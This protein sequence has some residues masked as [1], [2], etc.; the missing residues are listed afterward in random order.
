MR[1]A[2]FLR[3]HRRYIVNT[4]AAWTGQRKYDIDKLIRKMAGRCDDM[5]LYLQK[6]DMEMLSE[7]TAFVTAVMCNVHLF[8]E[9]RGT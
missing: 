7:V 2:R 9:D 3:R 1:A 4:V 5:G 8:D 6:S